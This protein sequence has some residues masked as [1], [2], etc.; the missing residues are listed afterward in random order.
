LSNPDK[1]KLARSLELVAKVFGF[2]TPD[3]EDI[4]TEKYLPPR[5]DLKMKK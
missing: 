1:Q 4:Y 5:E 3:I 2:K